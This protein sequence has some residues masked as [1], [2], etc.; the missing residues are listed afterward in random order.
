MMFHHKTQNVLFR[1][2]NH[3]FLQRVKKTFC[4]E[5]FCVE[6]AAAGRTTLCVMA[7]CDKFYV[8]YVAQAQTA[9]DACHSLFRIAV[10][11]WLRTILFMPYD[12]RMF[13][14]RRQVQF[15]RY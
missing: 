13:G 12:N 11:P 4:F 6:D 14:S 10:A 3:S 1:G 9:D 15:L 5:Q 2:G 7:E 8:E